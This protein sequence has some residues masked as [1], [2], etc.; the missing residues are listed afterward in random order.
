[1]KTSIETHAMFLLTLLCSASITTTTEHGSIRSGNAD[2]ISPHI[3]ATFAVTPFDQNMLFSTTGWRISKSLSTFNPK[4]RSEQSFDTSRIQNNINTITVG[5]SAMKNDT[6]LQVTTEKGGLY[7]SNEETGNYRTNTFMSS[8]A[9]IQNSFG[10]TFTAIVLNNVSNAFEKKVS[11]M[12]KLSKHEQSTQSYFRNVTM[13]TRAVSF[14]D[15]LKESTNDTLLTDVPGPTS[16]LILRYPCLKDGSC[17]IT[18]SMK[19]KFCRCDQN[20]LTFND[21]CHDNKVKQSSKLSHFSKYTTCHKGNND[22]YRK[23]GYFTVTSCPDDYYNSTIIEKCSKHDTKYNGP[24]VAV[25]SNLLFKNRFCGLCHNYST[26][27]VFKVKVTINPAVVEDVF[28][29]FLNLSKEERFGYILSQ[30]YKRGSFYEEIPPESIKPRSCMFFAIGNDA[31]NCNSYVNPVVGLV[32]IRPPVYRNTHCVPDGLETVCVG[33]DYDAHVEGGRHT[34]FAASVMFIFAPTNTAAETEAGTCDEWTTTI[35]E[36][37][38]C[39]HEETYT[40]TIIKME[41]VILKSDGTLLLNDIYQ[42]VWIFGQSLQVKNIIVWSSHLVLGKENGTEVHILQLT[43]IV[44][45]TVFD[46]ELERIKTEINNNQWNLE[47]TDMDLNRTLNIKKEK[48]DYGSPVVRNDDFPKQKVFFDIQKFMYKNV[49]LYNIAFQEQ[50]KICQSIFINAVRNKSQITIVDFKCQTISKRKSKQHFNLF[51][52]ANTLLTYVCFSISAIALVVL[53]YVYRKFG[54]SESIPGSNLE[55]VSVSILISN[56][57]FMVGIG[58]SDIEVVCY[59]IGVFLHYLW[60]SVFSFMSISS[61]YIA[62]NLIKLRSNGPNTKGGKRR[63]RRCLLLIGMVIPLLFVCPAVTLDN[64]D[65][66]S[67]VAGYGKDMC[68]PNQY[69]ANVIFFSGP[70]MFSLL[71]NF[72]CLLAFI[73]K[74]CRLNLEIGPISKS[75]PYTNAIIY[76]RLMIISGILWIFSLV[77]SV[78]ESE[79]LT[80]CFTV[81]CGLHGLFITVCEI[82]YQSER[83]SHLSVQQYP[84]GCN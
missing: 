56:V 32:G 34:T 27:A 77:A 39:S 62:G 23:T 47:L 25:Q 74:M 31:E 11:K 43:L 10:L 49:M 24:I 7:K 68:F 66:K 76:L 4:K 78:N 51:H 70:V 9:T 30:S 44:T 22:I 64:F 69:P 15:Q 65:N 83:V 38:L 29:T 35:V 42:I 59:M 80:Y 2:H 54:L 20:C 26:F 79:W 53:I 36:N 33:K 17:N 21:C 81:L 18:M 84:F 13:M 1:M 8:P 12:S 61:F 75:P 14:L 73:F 55:N 71:G 3:E 28:K 16:D 48:E 82:K 45:K 40:N 63:R 5:I 52:Q 72:A 50:K 41:N 46:K 57:L 6:K 19:H 67:L 60:L 58:A 37:G